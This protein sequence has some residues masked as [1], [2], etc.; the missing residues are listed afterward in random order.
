MGEI[1][2]ADVRAQVSLSL[3]TDFENFVV[4]KPSPLQETVANT[5]LDQVIRWGN[6]LKSL[7]GDK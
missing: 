5:M 1:M 7:R 6:A 2:V 3:L 4:F